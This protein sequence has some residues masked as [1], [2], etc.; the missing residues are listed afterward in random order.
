MKKKQL[1]NITEKVGMVNPSREPSGG[2]RLDILEGKPLV[3]FYPDKTYDVIHSW[4]WAPANDLRPVPGPLCA[5]S[6]DEIA[7][8]LGTDGGVDPCSEEG[9]A[10]IRAWGQSKIYDLEEE[11]RQNENAWDD[12]VSKMV[13]LPNG[14]TI[15]LCVKDYVCPDREYLFKIL[16][17]FEIAEDEFYEDPTDGVI[18]G[19]VT[20]LICRCEHTDEDFVLYLTDETSPTYFEEYEEED[21]PE[22]DEN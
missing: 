19:A 13:E 21:E 1:K 20:A 10:M 14:Q 15:E 6:M 8:G 3:R 7:P 22:E 5:G 18:E 11:V 16:N 12:L 4:K 17:F 9:K 2:L